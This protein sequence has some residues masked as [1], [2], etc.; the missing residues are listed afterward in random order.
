MVTCSYES[1]D[2]LMISWAIRVTD[3]DTLGCG[4]NLATCLGDLHYHM[5]SAFLSANYQWMI[6]YCQPRILISPTF[7]VMHVLSP[8]LISTVPHSLSLSSTKCP[9]PL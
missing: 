2:N 5:F 6:Q 7:E 4:G 3:I 8:L 1:V 9:P